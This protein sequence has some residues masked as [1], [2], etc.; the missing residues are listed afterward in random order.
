MRIKTRP[1]LALRIAVRLA[2]FIVFLGL[3]LLMY[4]ILKIPNDLP[5]WRAIVGGVIFAAAIMFSNL[6]SW[7]RKDIE[8]TLS[9]RKWK[10]KQTRVE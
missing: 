7:I 5:Y 3:V 4:K 2:D 6:F 1:Y 10:E 8:E 9:W